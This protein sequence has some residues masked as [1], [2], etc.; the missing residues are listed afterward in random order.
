M[1]GACAINGV[2]V[3]W[4]TS[5][6]IGSGVAS[7]SIYKNGG[8]LGSY[9]SSGSLT[10]YEVYGGEGYTYSAAA[11]DNAGHEGD[12]SSSY[13]YVE[14]CFSRFLDR[15]FRRDFGIWALN[16]PLV[17]PFTQSVAED[18]DYWR[19]LRFHL[20]PVNSYKFRTP[21]ITPRRGL[22]PIRTPVST[23]TQVAGGG[24]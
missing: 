10:D 8:F 6:D 18:Q 13:V 12:A 7:Y 1:A 9:S 3:E 16:R 21:T 23:G 17:I 20:V 19:R 5:S 14:L 15:T 24:L 2:R 11:V 4:G 22:T